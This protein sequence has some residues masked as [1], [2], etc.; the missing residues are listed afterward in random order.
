MQHSLQQIA[1]I[2]KQPKNA[3]LIKYGVETYD[4]N[5]LHL[6]GWG[7]AGALPII[8]H[9]ENE[10]IYPV[11]TKYALSN[12]D[13]FNRLLQEEEQVFTTVGGQI[14]IGAPI[15]DNDDI[16]KYTVNLGNNMPL[17]K[18]MQRVGYDAY[19]ADPMGLFFV[20]HDGNKPMVTYKCIKSIQDYKNN[21]RT[22]EYVCFKIDRHD[23]PSYSIGGV[24]LEM[25]STSQFFRF[26]D[27]VQDIVVRYDNGQAFEINIFPN[28][29]K[30]VPAFIISDVVD[31]TNHNRFM[32]RLYPI[33]EL[34]DCFLKDRSIE[35]LQKNYHGFAKAVEPF[36]QCS[37][38][39]GEGVKGG[40]PCPDCTTGGADIGTGFKRRTKISDVSRFPIDMLKEVS[41]DF[42]K[43]FGYVTPDIAS[44]EYQNKALMALEALMYRTHWGSN[45]PAKVDF[46]GTQ[47]LQETATKTLTDTQ[48]KRSVLNTL[49]DWCE[50]SE[51]MLIGLMVRF[52][53]NQQ[54]S[55]VC[56]SYN[57]DY[58][59]NTP[60]E[61]LDVVH[62]MKKNY[63][64]PSV[65]TALTIQY[66][67]AAYKNNPNKQIIETKKYLTYPIPNDSLTSVE[68]SEYV[69]DED[70]IACRYYTQ[71]CTTV[72]ESEWLT[73]EIPQ[74]RDK[75][76]NYCLPL[77]TKLNQNEQKETESAATPSDD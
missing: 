26:V 29:F 70:K 60:E 64:P 30:V 24:M 5:M 1:D 8:N 10:D 37:T 33:I 65:I 76:Y 57:R 23:Y 77:M 42:R 62:V 3:G 12:V 28:A 54:P 63:D 51:S 34:A 45:T 55:E 69:L 71:W 35:Q 50:N 74:L 43:I 41:F 48:P 53:T 52:Y 13:L 16:S 11:R 49:A 17:R 39:A 31:F 58:I 15:S 47:N 22:L 32:S 67:K 6:R 44:M 40:L 18:W 14:T 59:L 27:E 68:G 9:F 20:E 61:L 21:G 4:K 46:N 66:I 75:L 25:Q 56:V 38:C 2:I 36:L 19:N 73:L 72:T 7:M